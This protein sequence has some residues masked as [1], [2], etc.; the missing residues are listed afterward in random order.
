LSNV[1]TLTLKGTSDLKTISTDLKSVGT[2]AQQAKTPLDG[3]S[4]SMD[5]SSKNTA[6]FGQKLKGFGSQFSSS[7]ASIGTLGGTVL[8][9]S[10][11]Y[12]DLGDSQIAVDKAQLKVSKTTEA[13]GVAQGKLNDLTAKGITSGAAYEQ[14]QL[15]VKQALEAQSLA[16][17]ML[18]EKQEDHQRAQEN[19]WIGLVPTV[20]SAGASVVSVLSEMG[21][22]KGLGGLASKFSGVGEAVK[23]L[24]ISMK[25]A[26]IG[27]GIGAAIVAIGMALEAF[28]NN[29]FGVR[30]AVNEAGI[31]LGN[32]IPA[33]RPVLE[34]LG[35]VGDAMV[36]TFGQGGEVTTA[37]AESSLAIRE[38]GDT[39]AASLDKALRILDFQKRL[40]E[41]TK[42]MDDIL[43]ASR[44]DEERAAAI[45][46]VD[47]LIKEGDKLLATETQQQALARNGI[48]LYADSTGVKM[49]DADA[50]SQLGLATEGLGSASI[51][52]APPLKDL[53]ISVG[54]LAGTFESL[55][56]KTET[57]TSGM[58]KLSGGVN[59]LKTSV[60]TVNPELQFMAGWLDQVVQSSNAFA[61]STARAKTQA[62][63]L[64]PVLDNATKSLQ[65]F[66]G[67]QAQASGPHFN[68]GGNAAGTVI[69]HVKGQ[70]NPT[71]TTFRNGKPIAHGYGMAPPL[72]AANGIH[73][74]VDKPTWILAGEA[75][76]ERVDI[77][78]GGG[79]T[80]VNV[81]VDGVQRPARY[82][83]G[84]R[85]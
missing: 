14:A 70:S 61:N 43:M 31:A 42:H 77:G 47:D 30:D 33:L 34:L 38:F 80:I 9:L 37:L 46:A 53:G 36:K 18:T 84:T 12:Q 45:K 40:S 23:G 55:P 71:Y 11:Q 65:R 24:K 3:L 51:S 19:F 82:S 69:H 26:L 75:G 68:Y 29:W 20:T 13:V 27:T 39:S 73:K 21:G 2:A 32:S 83:I 48:K 78:G 4:K 16:Q 66:A 49:K 8:N 76:K 41:A 28:A 81:F 17:Q 57:A 59:L 15:D 60:T 64:A 22:T 50:T 1:A 62:A 10:R 25:T 74:T 52:A 44:N 72:V 5:Q 58:T 56:V 85:K 79:S 7:I 67:A 6:S 54:A 35:K 63:Q